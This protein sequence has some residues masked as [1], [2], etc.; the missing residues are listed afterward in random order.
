MNTEKAIRKEKF[1]KAKKEI[2]ERQKEADEALNLNNYLKSFNWMFI[3]PLLT[4]KEVKKLKECTDKEAVFKVCATV[5]YDLRATTHLIDGGFKECSHIKPFC[6]LID[7]A[8][9]M[10]LQKDY[11]GAINVLIPVIEGVMRH[12]LINE[13]GKTNEKI[14]KAED[15]LK[16]FEDHYLVKD[17][18]KKQKQYYKK[19]KNPSFTDGQIDELL[20]LEIV[21]FKCWLEMIKEYFKNNLFMDTRDG[22]VDDKLNR[23][24][25]LH[26]FNVEV[27]Y[28]LE[29]FLKV[30]NALSFLRF[31]FTL[32]DSTQH[33]S[34]NT[35]NEDI[36]YKWQAFEKV[37]EISRYTDEIKASVYSKYQG[38]DE[39]KFKKK[40]YANRIEYRMKHLK[41]QSL[42]TRLKIIELIF[43]DM[44][45]DDISI[46]ILLTKLLKK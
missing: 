5:F 12:Y 19:Q 30:F 39:D 24:S 13:R 3:S 14:M 29:N 31:V 21:Y 7:Q 1:Q 8:V 20:K 10:C 2:K 37:R 43:E 18:K 15:L 23:H 26:S 28:N 45:R 27:Y 22:S 6:Q 16:I 46:S 33:I 42:D 36:I 34:V 41:T 4:K 32:T 38:F 35:S 40:L 9:F 11:A 25:I 44:Q 17:Y